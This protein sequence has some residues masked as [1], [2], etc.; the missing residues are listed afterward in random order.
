MSLV[1]DLAQAWPPSVGIRSGY[2]R[3][4]AL[5][6]KVVDALEFPLGD[7]AQAVLCVTQ[8]SPATFGAV[9]VV[10]GDRWTG[11]VAGDGLTSAFLRRCAGGSWSSGSFSYTATQ[12]LTDVLTAPREIPIVTDQTHQSIV[13]GDHIV[14]WLVRPDLHGD[15]LLRQEHLTRVGFSGMPKH[16][17]HLSWDYG[18]H[19]AIVAM[20]DQYIP[21][22]ADG[23]T[24]CVAEARRFA[25]S[26]TPWV[27]PEA[28]G[29][30][31]IGPEVIGRDLANL[32]AGMHHAMSTSTLAEHSPVRLAS[33][34]QVQG[35]NDV[36]SRRML[37]ARERFAAELNVP[38]RARN[39]QA[40]TKCLRAPEPRSFHT[41]LTHGDLHVGQV[42][43]T[44]EG[45]HF[46]V[47]FEGDPLAPERAPWQSPLRDVA[48][49]V[50]SLALVGEVAA[51]DESPSQRLTTWSRR[52]CHE[53][54]RHYESLT[55][56]YGM[57]WA[58]SRPQLNQFIAEQI[59][60]ELNYATEVLPRWAYAPLGLVQ[61]L[62]EVGLLSA[63]NRT[64]QIPD[65]EPIGRQDIP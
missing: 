55:T 10:R 24:W 39:W 14:K 23:W 64:L 54:L 65:G 31:M 2:H 32:V 1:D 36:A 15:Q 16:F 3:H 57:T 35:W 29:P 25:A 6:G 33:P 45:D 61:R 27:T 22:A 63:N 62:D 8:D 43:K 44:L 42:L 21:H 60:A 37:L 38:L 52:T 28:I 51:V 53:F 30:E 40:L 48:H 19:R 50:T 47:D 26:D 13:F 9:C 41:T 17:G 7:D 56:E 12:P 4:P 58:F 11:A 59:A 18:D 46:I 5:D 34:S 20:V 49:L